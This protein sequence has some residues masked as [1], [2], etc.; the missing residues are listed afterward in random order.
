MTVVPHAEKARSTAESVVRVAR[1]SHLNQD[2]LQR[3][4]NAIKEESLKGHMS[5]EL[6]FEK[7]F[8]DEIQ[9]IEEYLMLGMGYICR[10]FDGQKN[11]EFMFRIEW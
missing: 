9:D 10:R 11:D 1:E 6:S 7:C 4:A 2:L 5:C 3:V 8:E